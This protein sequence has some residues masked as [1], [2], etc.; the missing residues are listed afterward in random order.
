MRF[1]RAV[2]NCCT[3]TIPAPSAAKAAT[4]AMI[5]APCRRVRR[6][7]SE[8]RI[9]APRPIRMIHVPNGD[10]SR[11][12]SDPSTGICANSAPSAASASE[13]IAA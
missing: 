13:T 6:Q 3:P 9:A 10:T 2:A 12:P 11:G 8:S 1:A 4:P 5:S 7:R